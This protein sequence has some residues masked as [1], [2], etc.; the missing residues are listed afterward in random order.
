MPPVLVPDSRCP[1]IGNPLPSSTL[2]SVSPPQPSILVD[3]TAC[4]SLSQTLLSQLRQL[5][6]VEPEAMPII[7][8][9]VAELLQQ[10]AVRRGASLILVM[11]L[12]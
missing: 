2:T 6:K 7:A 3:F 5:A 11:L 9:L 1:E 12:S 4:E 10:S 8:C